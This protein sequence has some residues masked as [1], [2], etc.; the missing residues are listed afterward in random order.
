MTRNTAMKAVFFIVSSI[1]AIAP[2]PSILA[3]T[4]PGGSS[5]DG[6]KLLHFQSFSRESFVIIVEQ[7]DSVRQ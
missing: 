1:G 7:F 2:A 6:L 5:L 4:V 3:I